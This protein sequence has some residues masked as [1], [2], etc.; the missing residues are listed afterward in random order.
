[1]RAKESLPVERGF[2]SRLYADE[3]DFRV[4]GYY[5][6]SKIADAVRRN[7][8]RPEN[9]RIPEK[10]ILGAAKH[11]EQPSLSEG[12]DELWYVEIGMDG[13]IA[14]EWNDAL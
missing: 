1:M 2:A 11:L 12:F 9:E 8:I 10:G 13:F 14:K 4:I 7:A 5:F 6:Q 3:N